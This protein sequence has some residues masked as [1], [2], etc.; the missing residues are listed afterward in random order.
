M[1]NADKIRPL[2]WRD[3]LWLQDNP[4]FGVTKTGQLLWMDKK[5]LQETNW[6]N[7]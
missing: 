3:K 4:Q 1:D 6:Q 7:F 2:F 5:G